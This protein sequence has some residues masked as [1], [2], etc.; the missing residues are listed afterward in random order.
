MDWSWTLIKRF[1]TEA[2][3]FIDKAIRWSILVDESR[4]QV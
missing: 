3:R 4:R 2:E 1:R